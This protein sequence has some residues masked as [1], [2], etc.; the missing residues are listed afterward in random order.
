MD[1]AVLR[2]RCLNGYSLDMEIIPGEARTASY[3]NSSGPW[4]MWKLNAD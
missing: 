3:D 1:Q 4:G 2:G